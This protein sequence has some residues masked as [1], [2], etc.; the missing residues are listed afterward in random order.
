MTF[1]SFANPTSDPFLDDFLVR[2]THD[3]GCVG[4][5]QL[6]VSIGASRC[7]RTNVYFVS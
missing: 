5:Q 4:T 7:L 6:K 1:V 3:P 2:V